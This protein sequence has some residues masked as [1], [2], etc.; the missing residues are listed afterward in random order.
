MAGSGLW[1][2][3]FGRLFMV[4][5]IV[6]MSLFIGIPCYAEEVIGQFDGSTEAV[7]PNLFNGRFTYGVPIEVPPG[8]HGI[9]PRLALILRSNFSLVAP[10]VGGSGEDED[11]FQLELGAIARTDIY[12][13]PIDYSKD[14]FMYANA[15]G[16][17]ALMNK[18]NGVY[19]ALIENEFFRVTK[20]TAQ[21]GKATWELVDRTGVKYY[22]GRTAASRQDSPADAGMIYKWC[23]DRVEDRNGNYLN[24]TYLKE[25]GQIYPKQID[26]TGWGSEA[27]GHAVEFIYEPRYS[28]D[29]EWG[30]T[31]FTVT[32]AKR[33]K[34]INAVSRAGGGDL[35]WS[36]YRLSYATGTDKLETIQRYSSQ[37]AASLS[38]IRF[39]W[40]DQIVVKYLK[41][42]ESR[43][44][45]KSVTDENGGKTSFE[46]RSTLITA[47]Y[48]DNGTT[49]DTFLTI[50]KIIREDGNGNQS[51]TTYIY[52]APSD[53][54]DYP[55]NGWHF[56]SENQFR[57][58][59]YV[60]VIGPAGPDNV[61]L[62]TETWFHQGNGITAEVDFPGV[63]VG[64]T[65]GKPFRKRISDTQGKIYSD[66][67][68]IYGF[69]PGT[70]YFRPPV[71]VDTLIYDGDGTPR[72]IRTV[73]NYD[74]YGN[75]TEEKQYGDLSSTRDD[76]TILRTF[77][78]NTD[79]WIVSLPAEE[80]VYQ[81]ITT[82][83]R[84]SNTKF[85][86]DDLTGCDATPTNNQMPVKGNLT[87]TVR[88][89]NVGTP[90]NIENRTAYDDHGNPVCTR[91]PNGNITYTTYDSSK[92]FPVAVTN[93]LG[94]ST[95][96]QY[97]GVDGIIADNGLYGQIKSVTDPNGAVTG[98][99][100]DGYGRKARE[101]KPDG[102]WTTWSYHEFGTVGS[103]RV[104][105]EKSTGEWTQE[106]FDGL[107]RTFRTE[108]SGP[109][110]KT[111]IKKSVY[112]NRGNIVQ[113]SLPYFS[114]DPA[115]FT[116]VDHDPSGRILQVT[117]PDSSRELTCYNASK[118]I[119]VTIDGEGH[120]RRE[121]RDAFDNLV[122]VEEY[123]GT[124]NMC[125]PGVGTPYSTTT[126]QYDV[127]GNL[128]YVDFNSLSRAEMRYDYLG[129][130]YWMKDLDMGTWSYSY[131]ANGNM[132]SQ[133]DAK[134]QTIGF[135]YDAL[136]RITKKDY[137]TGTDVIYTYDEAT[138][139][140]GI[141]RLTTM[142][143]AAGT[144]RYHYDATGRP[145]R[146]AR[147]IDG[148]A[149]QT[150][151]TYD[152]LGR[153][154]TLTYP[155][156]E[157]I[158][159]NYDAGGNLS[160]IPG[161][162]LYGD[163]TALGRPGIVSFADG[164]HTGYT[165]YPQ[166]GRLWSSTT[167]KE[168]VIY[169][170]LTYNYYADGNVSHIGDQLNDTNSQSFFYDGVNRLVQAQSQAYGTRQYSYDQRGNILSKEGAAY[171]YQQCEYYRNP[172]CPNPHKIVSVTDST[173]SRSFAYDNN[174]NIT[175]DGL[176]A[177]VYDYDNM[178]K[179]ITKGGLTTSFV[180]DGNG[181][182]VKK[183]TQDYTVIYIDKLYECVNDEC[184][185]YIFADDT[186]IA[187]KT[188]TSALYYHPNHL[189]STTVVTD[190]TGSKVEDVAYY[191]FGTTMSKT[192]TA[193]VNHL[194]TG[195]EFDATT[196][197]YNY[198][199]RMYDPDLGRFITPD[200][201]VPDPTNPQSFNRY[202]YVLNNPLNL[203]DPT[204]HED[205]SWLDYFNNIDRLFSPAIVDSRSPYIPDPAYDDYQKKKE[206][207]RVIEQNLLGYSGEKIE[208]DSSDH[209]TEVI[210]SDSRLWSQ[211]SQFGHV[212]LNVNGAVF[213]RAHSKWLVEGLDKYLVRQQNFRDSVGLVLN[214]T[215][216][217]EKQLIVFLNNR[218]GANTEYDIGSDSCSSN[219]ADA[220]ET[221]GIP[222]YG[223]WQ[224]NA[225]APVDVMINLKKTDRV[226]RTNWYGKK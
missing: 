212:A 10:L 1:R 40:K 126:Y 150:D 191:P 15:D 156:N 44:V 65:K 77:Y 22:F 202:S 98:T 61:Q 128:R 135:S 81:G 13:D 17:T 88:L 5:A 12:G 197:L 109:D 218:I 158:S 104:R 79:K 110:G 171:S 8:H 39:E 179:S 180:Y 177:I 106:Y 163:Y 30:L 60:K 94:Q 54:D 33:L 122:K 221:I 143:D 133:T 131:D 49:Y 92:I 219:V 201:I 155:D 32:T 57:G 50:N 206:L 36:S 169:A 203:I 69:T 64:V 125:D 19:R 181:A 226:I 190:V 114:G 222:V 28:N 157:T 105:T 58:F 47:G 90:S 170:S 45:L 11:G 48:P 144:V 120:R 34:E 137:P 223:A 160:S 97:Y 194:F 210:I 215:R 2:I 55:Y 31:G 119:T 189:G 145:T 52:P 71:Q 205:W 63:W 117:K 213:S 183:I 161:Y 152:G 217:E 115:Y 196:G 168:D 214:T 23:L 165:Y 193:N 184:G 108:S 59:R 26:Y 37:S 224:L 38:P 42:P 27:P 195:Q 134:G 199:A 21:D 70:P 216:M 62:I 154:K 132:I 18:G 100:Y 178:S 80:D 14:Y 93:P 72:Q 75:I 167:G 185:K 141:G 146:N 124:Y 89:N 67:T 198:N 66:E 142:S 101:T 121:T 4:W 113:T 139:I 107:G 192:G 187:L 9:E 173:G 41:P 16:S 166:N 172:P 136:N 149:Y 91:D 200:S 209:Y 24:I 153:I 6:L 186:R 204:G 84:V 102:A 207:R 99:E 20:K 56:L 82:K 76:R 123:S 129:R 162:V 188:P 68:T 35:P 220:L 46:Y 112:G 83:T 73:Y 74:S 182:R 130:K 51:E 25:Q 53:F 176:R 3:A 147:T 29:S 78:H 111:I 211:G 148:I 174:G 175:S 87:R 43:S 127:Q 7:T 103:Q 116:T 95:V 225:I 159:Y 96:T 118:G 138:S 164:V 140:N 151:T 86:Y 208:V 85:Y